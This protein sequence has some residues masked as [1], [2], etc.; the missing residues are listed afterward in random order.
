MGNKSTKRLLEPESKLTQVLT[1]FYN[2]GRDVPPEDLEVRTALFYVVRDQADL[3]RALAD[4][5]SS[6][7]FSAGAAKDAAV[8]LHFLNAT[9]QQELTQA[10]VTIEER[11]KKEK[12]GLFG[13]SKSS[14]DKKGD[15]P[16]SV[17]EFSGVP[18][19]PAPR[20]PATATTTTGSSGTSADNAADFQPPKPIVRPPNL[21]M[22]YN[23]ITLHDEIGRGAFGIVFSGEWQ[24]HKVAIKMLKAEGEQVDERELKNFINE[25]TLMTRMEPHPNVVMMIGFTIPPSPMCI[26]MEFIARG[27]LWGYLT[28]SV[29]ITQETKLMFIL[30][31]AEGIKYLHSQ[32]IVHRDL[33]ARNVLLGWDYTP[34]IAD[35]GMSREL[36]ENDNRT[37]AETGPLKWMPPESIDQK[38]Y[39]WAS[40]SWSFGVVCW[41]VIARK[42]PYENLDPVQAAS[43][44][45]YQ[46]LRLPIP[47]D[48]HPVVQDIMRQSFEKEPRNRPTFE[49]IC[50]RMSAIVPR[51]G[52]A[53]ASSGS[54]SGAVST[55]GGSGSGPLPLPRSSTGSGSGGSAPTSPMMSAGRLPVAPQSGGSSAS[56]MGTA[57]PG[58]ASPGNSGGPLPPSSQS[59]LTS[60]GNAVAPMPMRFPGIGRMGIPAMP[61]RSPPHASRNPYPSAG[62]LP[63]PPVYAPDQ[64]GYAAGHHVP[65]PLQQPP[66]HFQPV[67][68]APPQYYQ[69]QSDSQQQFQPPPPPQLQQQ[70]QP[71]PPQPAPLGGP[72]PPTGYAAPPPARQAV[73]SF[74]PVPSPGAYVPASPYATAPAAEP[75]ASP[76]Q[77]HQA[78][79]SPPV[80]GP[81]GPLPP[82]AASLGSMPPPPPHFMSS[83]GVRFA[84]RGP[85]PARLSLSSPS[86]PSPASGQPTTPP[87]PVTGEDGYSASAFPARRPPGPVP[88]RAQAGSQR[89]LL[90]SSG[91][92][93]SPP[94]MNY[95]NTPSRVPPQWGAPPAP[96]PAQE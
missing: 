25:A 66:A 35:F 55:S 83:D 64:N 34:K 71:Q 56:S 49:D 85:P 51:R 6:V 23:A 33:A 91:Q 24:G 81:G 18:A 72:P 76:P 78:P 31:I 7:E 19:L 26:V 20:G 43:R 50:N 48:I 4:K 84:P 45:A 39:S 2:S 36:Q 87:S 5:K 88:V 94:V 9:L 47:E 13:R 73:F 80:G 86:L 21:I 29:E 79:P 69:H 54:Y 53:A 30:G 1:E 77:Q 60:S 82:R 58:P 44:V 8:L 75:P 57:S 38:L 52:S 70:Q 92:D 61:L 74:A 59:S 62:Q 96:P 89:T 16:G 37:K 68:R 11:E 65:P 10:G 32:G 93:A 12:K 14:K 67:H 15:R 41:E 46:D 17:A 27:P 90:S 22:Q 28:S 40:D 3:L 63:P 42:P 95:Q